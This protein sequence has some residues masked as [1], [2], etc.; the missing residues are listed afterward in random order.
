MPRPRFRPSLLL[1]LLA[2]LVPALASAQK[3]VVWGND[4]ANQLHVPS[5][6]D[7]PVQVSSSYANTVALQ[8]DGKIVVW[9]PNGFGQGAVPEP[10]IARKVGSG[11]LHNVAIL[12]DGTVRA[13]GSD[14]DGRNGVP[15]NLTGVIDI[16]A[17]AEHTLALK[18]DGTVVAWGDDSRGQCTP[19]A[20][21]SN[22]TSVAAGYSVSLALKSDGTVVNWGSFPQGGSTV[23]AGLSGVVR[24]AAGRYHN[25]ALKA[26]GT[27]VGWGSNGYGESSAPT[28]LSAVRIA[29][30]DSF[31]MA[32]RKDGTVA[33]WG[34]NG[35]G[36]CDVPVGLTGVLDVAAGS[37]HCVAIVAAA[38]CVLDQK[39]IYEGASATG[40]VKLASPAGP[41]GAVVALSSDDPSVTVPDS[42]RVPAGAT[43]ATF[44]VFSKMVLGGDRTV[45]IQTETGETTVPFKL[46]VKTN[47]VAAAFDRST[48]V[49]GSTTRLVFSLTLAEAVRADSVF[50]LAANGEELLPDSTITIPAGAKSGKA[51][52][53]TNPTP[54]TVEKRILV[55]YRG[56]ASTT[57]GIT[58]TPLKASVRFEN[59]SVMSGE[60]ASGLVYLTTPVRQAQTV[61]LTSS[62]AALTVPASVTVK[63]G[64]TYAT[65]P[66]STTPVSARTTVRVTSTVNGNPYSG[67]ISLLPTAVL[68]TLTLPASVYG[69]GKIVGTVRLTVAAPVGGT[70]VTLVSGGPWLK[71]PATVTVPVGQYAATF[72]AFSSDV[73]VETSVVVTATAGG[74]SASSGTTV[75]PLSVS[76]LTLSASMVAGGGT[77][78]GTVTLN[79]PVAF[80]TD[81]TLTSADPLVGVPATVTIPA[82]SKTATF[83]VSTSSTV[84]AKNVKIT[85]SKHGSSVYRTLKVIP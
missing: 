75:K 64:A 58:L 76:A 4:S 29:A 61:A 60:A 67:S 77:V 37:A 32:V 33:V 10:W 36:E 22:V 25:L 18:G 83:T 5:T 2:T 53:I 26:D 27:I 47:T 65:F 79:T 84:S 56:L 15:P 11:Y 39:E 78:T 6:L 24:V 8:A 16:A 3:V 50:T 40:T 35:S 51:F 81:V 80:D 20:G 85:A 59:P 74:V 44:P 1:G 28:G 73:V 52:V 19:P 17:G 14:V 46:K 66:I 72:D 63:A 12:V 30:G 34:N 42:V 54:V 43:S 31:S 13:W 49:G 45:T 69:N 70:T 62:D 82:G 9:G 71:V 68:K 48:V 55:R 41:D 23:P 7:R 21:L 57:A 38:H